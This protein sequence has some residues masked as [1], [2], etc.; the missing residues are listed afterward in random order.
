MANKGKKINYPIIY[1]LEY[2]P[3]FFRLPN[4][5]YLGMNVEKPLSVYVCYFHKKLNVKVLTGK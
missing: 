5:S 4:R 3:F 1:T 2:V